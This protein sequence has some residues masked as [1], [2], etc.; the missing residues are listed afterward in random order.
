MI[1][2]LA[3]CDKHVLDMRR[4]RFGMVLIC[5]MPYVSYLQGFV[6]RHV[7]A[8]LGQQSDAAEAAIKIVPSHTDPPLIHLGSGN[9]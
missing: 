8:T 2:S 9:D 6:L 7:H 5:Q 1:H 4:I 3:P